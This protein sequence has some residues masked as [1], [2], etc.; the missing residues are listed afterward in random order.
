MAIIVIIVGINLASIKFQI[1]VYYSQFSSRALLPTVETSFNWV[2]Y[3]MDIRNPLPV[4][5][6]QPLKSSS[7]TDI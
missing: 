4:L 1:I 3:L 6:V 5:S 2:I 7:T